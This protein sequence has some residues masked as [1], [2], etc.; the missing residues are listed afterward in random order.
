MKRA[1]AALFLLMFLPQLSWAV[2]TSYTNIPAAGGEFFEGVVA[3]VEIMGTSDSRLES[4]PIY[5]VYLESYK[6]KLQQMQ[7]CGQFYIGNLKYTGGN[8]PGTYVLTME[9]ET[10]AAKIAL[11]AYTLNQFL[12]GQLENARFGSSSKL[13]LKRK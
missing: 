13:S 1:A 2:C 3:S 10:A 6:D 4:R 5:V 11:M 8:N 9:G 7:T 12:E